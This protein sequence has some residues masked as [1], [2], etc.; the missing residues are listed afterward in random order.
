MARIDVEVLCRQEVIS[1]MPRIG[2]EA[3]YGQEVMPPT[4]RCVADSTTTWRRV[5]ARIDV[6]VVLFKIA[7]GQIY[8][9]YVAR[10]LAVEYGFDIDFARGNSVK[11]DSLPATRRQAP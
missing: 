7:R 6:L 11:P 5:A 10:G 2:V 8:L 9:T 1:E 3:P 4:L